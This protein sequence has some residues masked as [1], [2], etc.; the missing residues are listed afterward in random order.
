MA[1]KKKEK[2]E[3]EQKKTLVNEDQVKDHDP[4]QSEEAVLDETTTRS[5]DEFNQVKEHIDK[6]QADHDKVVVLAQRIQADFDNYRKRNAS[7]YADSK[8]EGVRKVITGLLP[9]LDNFERA[10]GSCE[11]IDEKWLEGIRLVQRQLLEELKKEGLEEIAADGAFDP[12]LHEAVLQEE[13]EDA[14]SGMIL[15]VL[16]KGYKVK[17]RII[18]HSMVKVAK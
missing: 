3:A 15:A 16:Q 14:Q 4:A 11:G 17:D 7:I 8:E 10:L 1:D 2:L 18:R 6:L 5:R 9:V 13:V 12:T